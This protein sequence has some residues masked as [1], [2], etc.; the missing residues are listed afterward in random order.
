MNNFRYFNPTEIFFGKGSIAKLESLVPKKAKVMLLYGG[1][2]IKTNGVHS[3]VMKALKKHKVIEFGGIEPNPDYTT[4]KKALKEVKKEEVNFLLAVGGG[5]VIDGTK[6]VALTSKYKG[7]SPWDILC[8]KGAA[9]QVKKALP[10][11]TVLTLPATGSEFNRGAVISRREKRLKTEFSSDLVFPKFSILD[12]ETTYTLP[13]KQVRNGIVDAFVHVTEQYLT[14]PVNAILQDRQAEALLLSL[15][16]LAPAAMKTDPCDY[17]ARANLM[18]AAANALNSLISRGV[19][20]DWATH[21]IGHEITALYG[22]DHAETLAAILP[23]LLRYKK[24]QKQEK[25][26]QYGE[27][28]F[29]I[30]SGKREDRVEKAIAATEAFFQSLEIPTN[31]SVYG[32]DPDEAARIVEKRFDKRGT[33]LGEHGDIEAK[34]AAAILRMSKA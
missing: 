18:W 15:V 14:Y 17:D 32:I 12:P 30:T 24:D 25:L 26:L 34:D 3:Q 5:S 19:P 2:S 27:R 16:E 20:Q 7:K 22:L 33:K 13:L 6:F 11:G 28:I 9:T 29:G 1:G 4:L 21:E 8:K 23:S 31:L 10:F